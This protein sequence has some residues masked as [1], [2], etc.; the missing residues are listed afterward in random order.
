MKDLM[1]A[2][3]NIEDTKR[4]SEI[5]AERDKARV[6]R[7]RQERE[8]LAKQVK[9]TPVTTTIKRTGIVSHVELAEQL[10]L[11]TDQRALEAEFEQMIID[12]EIKSGVRDSLGRVKYYKPKPT[13]AERKHAESIARLKRVI[14]K[15]HQHKLAGIRLRDG[16]LI[17]KLTPGPPPDQPNTPLSPE[18]RLARRK[19]SQK[20]YKA[21]LKQLE[22]DT[23]LRRADGSL[24]V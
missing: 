9:P 8:R 4:Q 18:E 7:A 1:T 23:G 2:L 12:A 22:I 20:K 5:D 13:P 16:E 6:L 14:I 11:E 15:R 24:I 19:A 3:L 17:D 21:R 10:Q